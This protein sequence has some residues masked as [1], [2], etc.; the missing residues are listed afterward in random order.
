[1]NQMYRVFIMMYGADRSVVCIMRI[2]DVDGCVYVYA[3]IDA[4]C[5][6]DADVYVN[7]DVY[8]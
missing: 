7:A 5:W 4:L 8:V 2:Y 3:N 1:M 6:F